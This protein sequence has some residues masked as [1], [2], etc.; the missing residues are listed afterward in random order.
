MTGDSVGDVMLYGR[1]AG[2]L[3][4]G[5]AIVSDIIYA[6]THSENKY[7]TFKNTANADKDVKF[8]SDFKSAYYMRL[9][10][11]DKAGILAKIASIFSKN[12]ISIVE[13]V[14]KPAR[15]DGKVPLVLITHETKELS[16]RSAVAKIDAL[17]EI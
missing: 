5:S 15:A 9:T 3:P 13:M 16:V 12:G 1:G 6:A 10:V 7:S 2:A 4:T 17:E 8:V 11:E 14:Q